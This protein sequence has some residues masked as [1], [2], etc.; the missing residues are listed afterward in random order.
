MGLEGIELEVVERHKS[1][2]LTW[3]VEIIDLRER[4][5]LEIIVAMDIR[6]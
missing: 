3:N 4:R 6:R 5:E 1:N 2:G